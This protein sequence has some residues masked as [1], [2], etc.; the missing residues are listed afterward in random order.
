M[1][2]CIFIYIASFTL[3]IIAS[4]LPC[5]SIIATQFSEEVEAEAEEE[6]E[7]YFRIIWD[8]DI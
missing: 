3:C 1:L 7:E 5:K 2:Y 6:E 8:A 4:A